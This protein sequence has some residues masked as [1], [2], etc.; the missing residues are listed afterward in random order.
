MA[1]ES[2]GGMNVVRIGSRDGGRIQV[3]RGACLWRAEVFIKVIAFA[4]L[5]LGSKVAQD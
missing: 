3:F 5:V 1:V 2:G 4:W